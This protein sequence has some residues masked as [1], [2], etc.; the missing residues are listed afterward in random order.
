MFSTKIILILTFK[1]VLILES[2]FKQRILLFKIFFG[3]SK[4]IS[5]HF[6]SKFCLF[7]KTDLKTRKSK[8]IWLW[9]IKK[10]FNSAVPPAP[11]EFQIVWFVYVST[12]STH[13]GTLALSISG[14]PSPV[15]LKGYRREKDAANRHFMLPL[16]FF[17]F[18]IPLR[19]FVNP[20]LFITHPPPISPQFSKFPNLWIQKFK[21]FR[22]PKRH[23]KRDTIQ[24]QQPIISYR[25]FHTKN[26][27]F[28]RSIISKN[29]IS[30][31]KSRFKIRIKFS[32]TKTVNKTNEQNRVLFIK[33]K[34]L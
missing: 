8:I 5:T 7:Q 2:N 1:N 17:Y 33:P 23:L 19:H 25:I 16:L 15:S 27:Q 21:I 22:S 31:S 12:V 4:F 28:K 20:P 24:N 11:V 18:Q 34:K 32:D 26:Q 6:A 3:F 30:T 9:W 29:W 10:S 13:Q 14:F